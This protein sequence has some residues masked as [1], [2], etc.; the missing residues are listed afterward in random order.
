MTSSVR[1]RVYGHEKLRSRRLIGE[2]LLDLGSLD[3]DAKVAPAATLWLTLEPR[4]NTAVSHV[5]PL[6]VSEDVKPR[7]PKTLADHLCVGH[8]H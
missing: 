6:I 4:T 3:L 7:Q 8:L 2:C 5:M 1:L